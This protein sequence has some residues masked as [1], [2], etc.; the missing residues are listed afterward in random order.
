MSPGNGDQRPVARIPTRDPV[1][2]LPKRFYKSA[3][4]AP[5]GD[6]FAV[7]LD[8]RPLRTPGKAP[9]VVPARALAEALSGEWAAQGAEID[10]ATMPLTRIVNSAIDAV[11]QHVSEV[12][13][14]IVAFAGSDLVCYRAEAPPQ[15]VAE[16]AHHW[17]PI[18]GW[19]KSVLGAEFVVASG[20]MP[21]EQPARVRQAVAAAVADHGPLRIAALHTI[22]T[23]TGSAL[24]A[25]AH[26][27]AAIGLHEAWAA[28]HVDEDWQIRQWGEDAEAGE[29]RRR[30]FLEMQAASRI[31]SLLAAP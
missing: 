24:I 15:L 22:V 1:R 14:D 4:V 7:H 21:V 23:L 3:T 25:L 28:A 26:D 20:I 11:A 12:K 16:Q 17:D 30:R 13:A 27:R 18:L 10:P 19:A 8:G 6:G 31:L 9:L 5:A 2:P 29:R